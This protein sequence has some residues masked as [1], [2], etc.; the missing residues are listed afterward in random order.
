MENFERRIA[1]LD[2]RASKDSNAK[3]LEGIAARYNSLS[4]PIPTKS[5]ATFREVLRPGAFRNVVAQKQDVRMLINHDSS[6]VIGRTKSGTLTLRDTPQG[7]AYRCV[8]PDSQSAND[9]HESVK[10]GDVNQCSFGFTLGERDCK[11]KNC[12]EDDLSDL[13]KLDFDEDERARKSGNKTLVRAIHNVSTL[14]EISAVAFPAYPNGTSCEAR[15]LVLPSPAQ[16]LEQN[17]RALEYEI[18]QGSSRQRRKDL[19]KTILS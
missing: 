13:D 19:L 6:K 8:L 4:E 11:Y 5:G 10:R 14:H 12:D 2:L 9:L 18:E 16:V 3:I 15:S 17:F 1:T 7:L